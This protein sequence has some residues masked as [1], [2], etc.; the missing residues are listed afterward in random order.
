MDEEAPRPLRDPLPIWL[1][2]SPL[3]A[4]LSAVGLA[5]AAWMDPSGEGAALCPSLRWTALPCPGCG[6][7]RAVSA[8]THLEVLDAL[9]FNPFGVI[10]QSVMVLA[11][12]NA[13][14][15]PRWRAGLRRR[16]LPHARSLDR[17]GNAL[18]IAFFAYG[19]GRLL[20]VVA[21]LWAWP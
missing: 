16:L 20:A 14:L 21:G 18:L 19:L 6:L 2:T 9:R 12:V 7:T 3:V 13:L 8:M 17:L 11:L 5:L 4:A 1:L 10:V 15:G